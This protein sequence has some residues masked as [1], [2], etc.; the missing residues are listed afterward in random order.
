MG[1]ET[2]WISKQSS[3]TGLYLEDNEGNSGNN[4]ITTN[5]SRGDSV[6]W[7][8]KEGGGITKITG[9]S[10]KDE[11]GNQNIFSSGP[12]KVSDSEWQGTVSTNASG[13][14]FYSIEYEIDGT[15]YTDDP[16]L[17]VQT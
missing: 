7:K 16:E 15:P 2:I 17:D 13:N 14:E 9:I 11:P 1:A 10:E 4:T 12:S 3:G 5:V 6:T 8:L